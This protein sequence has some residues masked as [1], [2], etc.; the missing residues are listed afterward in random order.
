MPHGTDIEG[1]ESMTLRGPIIWLLTGW[2]TIGTIA[3]AEIAETPAAPVHPP[4]AKLPGTS[5]QVAPTWPLLRYSRDPWLQSELRATLKRL[6]LDRAANERRLAVAL[7]DITVRERPRVAAVNAHEMMY[8]ASLPKIAILLGAFQKASEGGLELNEE[9]RR[10]LTDMIRRSSNSAATRMLEQV[11]FR[12]VADMLQ[13]A[14]YRLYD[15]EMNGGLWVGKPYAKQGAWKRDPLYNL[16]HAATPF[17][18]ARFYYMLDTGQLVSPQA[19]AEM[20]E[21]LSD[22]AIE[23]KFVAGLSAHRPGSE[24]LRKSGTWRTFHSDS[25]IVER[26]GRRY[27]AVGMANHPSGGRWLS[28]LI[29]ALDDLVFSPGNVARDD[30]PSTELF[31][32]GPPSQARA[33]PP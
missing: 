5:S 2:I 27:I 6:G 29:V 14:R 10:L 15:P 25:A 20:R 7:V 12:Y 30:A 28:R 23:H 13:S 9:N 3:Q 31:E 19:S 22:P 16:S 8:A 24:I 17:E 1:F 4:G 21:M 11:G 33:A 18:V 32:I 26:N